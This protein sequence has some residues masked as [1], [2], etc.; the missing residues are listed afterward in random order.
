MLAYERLDAWKVSHELAIAVVGVVRS[1]PESQDNGL[2]GDLVRAAILAPAK[3]ARG[4]GTHQRRMFLHC[5]A[6]ASGHLAEL[7]D[8]LRLAHE[9]GLLPAEKWKEL[10]AIRGR[11]AF[12]TGKLLS[13]FGPGPDQESPSNE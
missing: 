2:M 10:D 3:I 11:A 12:Y 13:S 1:L 6:M 9:T 4:W 5:V 8:Y 7:S